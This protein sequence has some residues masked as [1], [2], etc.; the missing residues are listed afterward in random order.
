MVVGRSFFG[1][2]VCMICKV[3]FLLIVSKFQ[4]RKLT[5][6]EKKVIWGAEGLSW[7]FETPFGVKSASLPSIRSLR[8]LHDL[9]MYLTLQTLEVG[10]THHPWVKSS[11]IDFYPFETFLIK[12]KISFRRLI[13]STIHFIPIPASAFRQKHFQLPNNVIITTCRK[14]KKNINKYAFFLFA[15]RHGWYVMSTSP[16]MLNGKCCF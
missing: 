6:G 5:H 16:R 7:S 2:S 13:T 10:S 9:K 11:F 14:R 3:I 1:W 12:K 4:K 8:S 15:V